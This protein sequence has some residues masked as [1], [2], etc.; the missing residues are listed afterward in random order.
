MRGRPI[1]QFRVVSAAYFGLSVCL[2]AISPALA[3]APE[4]QRA[5]TTT[6]GVESVERDTLAPIGEDIPANGPEKTTRLPSDAWRGLDVD[7]VEDILSKIALPPKSAALHELW[8]KLMSANATPPSGRSGDAF[9]AVRARALLRAGLLQPISEWIRKRPKAQNSVAQAVLD[10]FAASADLGLNK[11]DAACETA[12]QLA[13]PTSALPDALKSDIILVTG[14]CAAND[15]NTSAA[16]LT[17]QLARDADAEDSIAL[18]A[19]EAAASGQKIPPLKGIE[20][21]NLL[22]Y[23][24]LRALGI[25]PKPKNFSLLSP[26]LLVSIANDKNQEPVIRLQA[27]EAAFA[28]HAMDA[29]TV[30]ALYRDAAAVADAAEDDQLTTARRAQD[31]VNAENAQDLGEKVRTIKAYLTSA[32]P[33]VGHLGAHKLAFALI[34]RIQPSQQTAFLSGL[35]V[36][37]S[38]AANRTDVAKAWGNI[39]YASRDEQVLYWLGAIDIAVVG[40]RRSNKNL[41]LS[42]LER[43]ALAGGFK[44]DML[45][46]L[47]TVLDA[48][49]FQ[50]PIPLWE[51]ASKTPQP[52]G[53]FLPATGVLSDLKKAAND[54]QTG[55]VI[56]LTLQALGPGGPKGANILTLG[57][58][59]RALRAAGLQDDAHNL[60]IEAL[61]PSW[62]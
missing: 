19:L 27:A 28:I 5:P 11:S 24:T 41:G 61:L 30:V 15:G 6:F 45:H 4:P 1:F 40:T 51:A 20:K 33:I 37:L 62:P 44:P 10:F 59:I 26:P 48:L 38:L 49:E 7:T 58:T 47:V 3:Q 36:R 12:K 31:F 43:R 34:E 16:G 8:R 53:G 9:A 39:I 14:F 56:L 25:R 17:A 23:K 57:D 55:R 50:V 2:S 35:A 54:R 52:T 18:L 46:R 13:G 42:A 21:L 60:A 32:K 22:D 29:K